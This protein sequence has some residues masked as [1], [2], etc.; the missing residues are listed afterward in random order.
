MGRS[1]GISPVKGLIGLANQRGGIG[2]VCVNFWIYW[3]I[4]LD[5]VITRAWLPIPKYQ[6]SLAAS[7]IHSTA[8]KFAE[9]PSFFPLS[10][11]IP[12]LFFLYLLCPFLPEAPFLSLFLPSLLPFPFPFPVCLF[13]LLL[14]PLP[15]VTSL[16]LYVLFVPSLPLS[17]FLPPSYQPSEVLSGSVWASPLGSSSFQTV[18]PEPSWDYSL[19]GWGQRSKMNPG[20]SIWFLQQFQRSCNIQLL[21]PCNYRTGFLISSHGDALLTTIR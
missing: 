3:G 4:E 2:K 16:H 8:G 21:E 5:W 17:L 1:L 13:C 14:P 19:L 20:R 12:F 11:C 10:L 7:T 15:S 9:A 18:L 6:H